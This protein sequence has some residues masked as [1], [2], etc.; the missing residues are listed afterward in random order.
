MN[1]TVQMMNKTITAN[2]IITIVS[3]VRFV[4]VIP[5]EIIQVIT[6]TMMKAGKLNTVVT[7]GVVPA[8]AVRIVGI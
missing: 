1:Q 5:L 7:P 6:S 2:L 8:A 4:C 3:F